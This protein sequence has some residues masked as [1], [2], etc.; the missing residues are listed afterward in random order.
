MDPITAFAMAQGAIA[1]I[2]KGVEFY[3][4]CQ[5]VGADVMNITTEVSGH[6][7]KFMDAAD[8]VKD[9]AEKQRKVVPKK[10]QTGLNSQALDNVIKARQIEQAET[11]LREMLI[12]QTPGL[13]SIWTDFEKER[14][15]LR[16]LQDD[17]ERL[18][19]LE[20]AEKAKRRA[21][22]MEAYTFDIAVIA[23]V[24]SLSLTLSGFFYWLVQDRK[25]RWP[26][27][28]NPGS[29][30]KTYERYRLGEID[31][32]RQAIKYLDET[33]HAVQK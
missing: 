14:A 30:Q 12:Y 2:K 19:A 33:N 22:M 27:L 6:I 7:G 23:V 31:K 32:V 13:G 9:A 26:E 4:D 21:Q 24:L 15:R 16:K 29:Y 28:D 5:K 20:A 10:G 25:Q 1:A 11:E 18:E 3:K 8:V 17:Q